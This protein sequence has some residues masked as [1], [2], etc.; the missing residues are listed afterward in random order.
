MLNVAMKLTESDNSGIFWLENGKKHPATVNLVPGERVYGE[1]LVTINKTEYRE[2]DPYRSKIGSALMKGT[3]V[4]LNA[5]DKV[6]Y[7]GVASGT[8]ASHVSDIVTATG[9]VFGIDIADRVMRELVFVA[10]KRK[11]LFPILSDATKPEEYRFAVDNVDFVFQDVAMPNQAE[12]LIMNCAAFLKKD[13]FAM[14]SVKARSI[15]V[16]ALPSEIFK[17]VEKKLKEYF[18]VIDKKRLEPFEKDHIMFLLKIKKK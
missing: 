3:K 6:L 10:E 12:I 1:K 9:T 2:W 5:G 16:N 7:L 18:E 13:G 11:N 15:D 8:T 17:K 14:I 4:P